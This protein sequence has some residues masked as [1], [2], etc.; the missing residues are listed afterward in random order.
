M[1][2]APTDVT[3]LLSEL[4]NG[5]KEAAAQ[6]FPLVYN[7]LRRIA[8]RYM[9]YERPD[10]TLQATALVH[11]AFLEVAGQ[12]PQHFQNR[13][14]FLAFAA[15]VMRNFLVDYARGRNAQKRAGAHVIVPLEQAFNLSAAIIPGRAEGGADQFEEL[16]KLDSALERL[17]KL[18]P[19]QAKIVELRFFG[20]LGV[21]ETADIV[22]ISPRTVKRDWNVA[23]AWLQAELESPS[24]GD[25]A[26]KVGS[27]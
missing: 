23:R 11:E 20:G 4:E 8:E 25:F 10:H 18:D 6:L 13:T 27:R 19:R 7:E 9:R 16:L 14:H 17:A 12:S 15:N 1:E 24:H 21:E 3:M 26:G 22:G 5:N 2:P